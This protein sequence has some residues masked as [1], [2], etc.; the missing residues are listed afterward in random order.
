MLLPFRIGVGGR[1][2][3][4]DQYFSWIALEDVLGAT[5]FLLHRDD[6]HGPVNLTAPTPETNAALT[7]TLGTVLRRPT[8]VPVP[9][10]VLTTLVGELAPA[11]LLSSKRVMPA[12]LDRAGFAFLHPTLEAALR[13]TLGTDR[14][15]PA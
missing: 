15:E 11:E 4:G 2:G 14:L 7:R 3:H 8:F 12:V 9:P 5:L 1:L 6:I 10:F 13:H